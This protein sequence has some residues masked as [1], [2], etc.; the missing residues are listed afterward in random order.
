MSLLDYCAMSISRILI[1]MNLQEGLA[2]I[3]IL[4]KGSTT[5]CKKLDHIW[6]P[7]HYTRYHRDGHLAL[8]FDLTFSRKF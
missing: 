3:I 2:T 5:H 1:V 8:D 4:Q 6:V 7:F